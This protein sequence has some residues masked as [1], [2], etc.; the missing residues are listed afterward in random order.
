[1]GFKIMSSGDCQNSEF[2]CT[3]NFGTR[4]G[5]SLA[6]KRVSQNRWF[7]K[8]LAKLVILVHQQF[9]HPFGCFRHLEAHKPK[10]QKYPKK[11]A[12]T[13][14][15][16]KFARTSACFPVTCVRNP[17]ETVQKNLF[18]RICLFW[19][20]FLGGENIFLL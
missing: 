8:W 11:R 4:L 6:P 10:I 2:W 5:G 20:D 12:Y 16:E 14:F 19:V 9:W 3:S 13:S 15:L 7:S 1:M 17:T 18:R